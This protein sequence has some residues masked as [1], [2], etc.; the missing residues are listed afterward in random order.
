MRVECGGGCVTQ[1]FD[2]LRMAERAE[3]KLP[4]KLADVDVDVATE[5]PS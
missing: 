1:R 5:P 4:E 2:V 3:K